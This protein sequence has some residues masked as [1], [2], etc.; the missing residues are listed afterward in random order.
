MKLDAARPGQPLTV[1]GSAGAT[2]DPGATSSG[3]ASGVSAPRVSLRLAELGVRP[4]A[5]L[6][7]LSRTSGGGAILAIG[8]DRLAVSRQI[9]ASIEVS[10]DVPAH[11]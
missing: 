4:G 7:I 2:D 6:R 3:N 1:L 11:G 9:L 10:E 5:R 8:D